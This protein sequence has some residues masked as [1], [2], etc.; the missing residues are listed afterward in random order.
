MR[1]KTFST[2]AVAAIAIAYGIALQLGSGVYQTPTGERVLGHGNVETLETVYANW[3]LAYEQVGGGVGALR[4]PL[5]YSPNLS[6]I[7]SRAQ[8]VFDLNLMDGSIKVSAKGLDEGGYDVWL[9]D[10]K[11][12]GTLQPEAGDT[13]IKL[14][15][16]MPVGDV[17]TL[18][19][20]LNPSQLH[21]FNLDR[22]AV[23]RKGESP[24]QSLVITGAPGLLQQ[25]YYSGQYWP[26]AHVGDLE[27]AAGQSQ[28]PAFDFLLP[29]PANA[30]GHPVS[31]TDALGAQIGRA[32]V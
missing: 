28:K 2:L 14:G 1:R 18:E 13:L 26:M 25:L 16:L 6:T 21:G 19:T 17:A 24:A 15:E 5:A 22:V 9:V 7:A 29:K 23:T 27:T 20:R 8:G 11:P 3:R 32:H 31:L 12:G 4:L 30:D 10:N